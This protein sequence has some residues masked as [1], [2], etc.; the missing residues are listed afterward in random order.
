MLVSNDNAGKTIPS[1]V[2]SQ[3]VQEHIETEGRKEQ[4]HR[5]W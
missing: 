3:S 1:W 2:K 5:K 4:S